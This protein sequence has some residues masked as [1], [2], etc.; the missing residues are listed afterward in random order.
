ME[1]E[2]RSLKQHEFDDYE[3]Y[4]EQQYQREKKRKR[5]ASYSELVLAISIVVLAVM[6]FVAYMLQ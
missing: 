6:L 3:E 4:L 5:N 1:H 2:M